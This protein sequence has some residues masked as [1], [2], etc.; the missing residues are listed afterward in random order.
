MVRFVRSML[1]VGGESLVSLDSSVHLKG[2][3]RREHRE[4]RVKECSSSTPFLPSS[5]NLPHL[6]ARLRFS[7]SQWYSSPRTDQI[8][9][10][11]R[12]GSFEFSVLSAASSSLVSRSLILPL[13]FFPPPRDLDRISSPSSLVVCQQ[14]QQYL[15]SSR[16]WTPHRSTRHSSSIDHGHRPHSRWTSHDSLLHQFRRERRGIHQRNASRNL[17]LLAGCISAC[18]GTGD[19]QYVLIFDVRGETRPFFLG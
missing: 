14:P 7:P 18:S 12:N 4:G 19:D 17:D 3:R 9:D 1:A 10:L 13:S 6:I 8:Q 2:E 5:S 16:W 11:E 15:D